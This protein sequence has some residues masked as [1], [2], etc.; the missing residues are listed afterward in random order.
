MLKANGKDK[1]AKLLPNYESIISRGPTD[2][3]NCTL[4]SKRIDTGDTIPIRMAPR[5]ISYFQQDEV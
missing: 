4:L 5:R 2:I 3:G 1:L